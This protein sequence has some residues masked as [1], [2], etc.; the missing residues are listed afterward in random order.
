MVIL[1]RWPYLTQLKITMKVVKMKSYM[2]WG[3]HGVSHQIF[4]GNISEFR[5]NQKLLFD[6]NALR[7]YCRSCYLSLL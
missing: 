6:E 4:F 3:A 7:Y 5:V 1:K 2:V